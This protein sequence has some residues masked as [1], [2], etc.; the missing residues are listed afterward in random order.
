MNSDVLCGK[1]ILYLPSVPIAWM[2]TVSQLG[3]KLLETSAVPVSTAV[4]QRQGLSHSKNSALVWWI[5][6]EC[7]SLLIGEGNPK[8]GD[9]E[10]WSSSVGRKGSG[11]RLEF[12]VAERI[13]QALD[14]GRWREI[15][16]PAW[17]AG[18]EYVW[19]SA[20]DTGFEE[21]SYMMSFAFRKMTL[22]F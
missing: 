11:G 20:A 5:N 7:M 6:N 3:S 10:A 18:K 14:R 15:H 19:T 2:L 21:E 9:Y 13:V 22:E 12:P 4:F 17:R 8:S 16:S 1:V